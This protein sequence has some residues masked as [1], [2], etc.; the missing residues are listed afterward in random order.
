M[1]IINFKNKKITPLASKECESYLSSKM[2]ICKK[3]FG[4]KN[5]SDKIVK[6]MK[7]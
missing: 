1:K 6:L 7:R 2:F 5:T 3:T 4:D